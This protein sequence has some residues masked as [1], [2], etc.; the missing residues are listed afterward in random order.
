MNSYLNQM[1]HVATFI[2]NEMNGQGSAE[3]HKVF[4]GSYITTTAPR[5]RTAGEYV[6]TAAPRPDRPG[7]YVTSD[8]KPDGPAGG[9]VSSTQYA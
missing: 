6:T 1:E 4:G 2:G 8:A 3:G 7:S 5:P 9:Y